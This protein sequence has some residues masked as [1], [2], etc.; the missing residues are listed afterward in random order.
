M[1]KWSIALVLVLSVHSGAFAQERSSALP[2]SFSA[3]WSTKNVPLSTL[4]VI[5]EHKK[6][7]K[8]I[9]HSSTKNVDLLSFLPPPSGKRNR[10]LESMHGN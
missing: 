10:L 3:L 2:Q 7:K 8:E 9:H 1:N 4:G 5:G 6:K